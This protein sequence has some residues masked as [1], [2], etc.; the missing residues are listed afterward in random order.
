MEAKHATDCPPWREGIDPRAL[1]R[2]SGA[3]AEL[4]EFPVLDA[5]V[6]R[7]LQLC[8][9]VDT[10]AADLVDALE[11]DPTFAANLLRYCNSAAAANPVRAK[12]VRQAVMLVGRRAL[13][14]LA[15]EAASSSVR[16]ATAAPR[17]GR[18][19]CTRSRLPPVP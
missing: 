14:R 4:A 6:M 1:N 2:V 8:D 5:T 13:R 17:L 7:I 15:M 10:T 16:V 19:T 9:D 3:I 11:Q 18:C 12:T